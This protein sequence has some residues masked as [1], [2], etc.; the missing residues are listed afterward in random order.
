MIVVDSNIIAYLYLPS[1]LSA[2]AEQLLA[3]EPHWAAPALW[4]SELRNVL[5]LYIRKE[6]LSFEHAYSIQTEAETL[7]ADS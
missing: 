6:L 1:D 4:R 2:E 5:A 3:K 7:L